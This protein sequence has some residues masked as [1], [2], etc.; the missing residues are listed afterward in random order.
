MEQQG[1]YLIQ[2]P[3]ET[4]WGALNDPEILGNCITGCQHVERVDD[5]HFNVKVKAK[6]GPVSAV[7]QA[8]LALKDLDPPNGYAIDGSVKGGAAGFGK[9]SAQ[10][11]L[12]PESDG[13]E[14]R[15]TYTVKANVGG[16]LAQIGSRLVDGAARKMADEFF[17]A[18]S[19]YLNEQAASDSGEESDKSETVAKVNDT[20]DSQA[21]AGP[22]QDPEPAHP[23]AGQRE[24]T[25]AVKDKAQY[26]KQGSGTIWLIAF[27]VRALAVVLAL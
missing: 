12:T 15:L 7:F 21:S 10:V 5:T 16:K 22:A 23:G 26:E 8:E 14:T 6:I 18:F 20:D 11:R 9:G 3:R 2:A 19:Q 24:A 1:E 25:D 4:V 13:I 27:V 17:A